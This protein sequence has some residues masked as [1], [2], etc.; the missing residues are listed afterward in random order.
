MF[1]VDLRLQL[2]HGSSGARIER[3]LRQLV[4]GEEDRADRSVGRSGRLVGDVAEE[5]TRLD[6]IEQVVDRMLGIDGDDDR[7]AVPAMRDLGIDQR[8][9]QHLAVGVRP[10]V[11]AELGRFGIVLQDDRKR[12]E[13]RLEPLEQCVDVVLDRLGNDQFVAVPVV[14]ELGIGERLGQLRTLVE[15]PHRHVVVHLDHIGI[16]G[17]EIDRLPRGAGRFLVVFARRLV[18][19]CHVE[20]L[21][22]P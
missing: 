17:I 5:F 18:H 4:G 22:A 7:G 13:Q 6:R 19:E 16:E 8:F 1:G 20:T 15:G 21:P 3:I 10:L 12:T 14:R 9:G 11:E 2:D